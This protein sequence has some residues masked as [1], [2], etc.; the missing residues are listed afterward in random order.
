MQS[1]TGFGC[2]CVRCGDVIIGYNL[3]INDFVCGD[4]IT[5]YQVGAFGWE[6]L[7]ISFSVSYREVTLSITD[8][9][10]G[11]MKRYFSRKS[12]LGQKEGVG[13]FNVRVGEAAGV[14]SERIQVTACVGLLFCQEQ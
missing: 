12:G 7:L 14:V 11:V 6:A 4:V 9:Y 10:I 3:I 2:F 8:Q 13:C 5:L 1:G